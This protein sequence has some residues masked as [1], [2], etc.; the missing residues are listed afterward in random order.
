MIIVCV[1]FSD[2]NLFAQKNNIHQQPIKIKAEQIIY[3]KKKN[4]YQA[5]GHV[6]LDQGKRH[7]EADEMIVNLNTNQAKLKGNIFLKMDQDWIRA[8][9]A[10]ID[11]NTYQGILSQAQV[12]MSENHIYIKGKN[13]EKT[14]E[15]TYLIEDAYLTT[16]D[17]E[18][19][20]WHFT[21]KKVKV[22]LQGLSL[23]HISEPTRRS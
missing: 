9:T 22:T 7:I 23:I 2:V 10:E 21:A 13:I 16:C 15:Q 8:E 11:L 17:G 19:P 1:F 3:H 12:F 4:T 14:G 6:F 20:A 18:A 5:Q